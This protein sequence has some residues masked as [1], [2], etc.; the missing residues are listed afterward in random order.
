MRKYVKQNLISLTD[1]LLEAHENIQS[2][3][4]SNDINDACILLADCQGC[5]ESMYDTIEESEG[6]NISTLSIISEYHE[7]LFNLYQQ[8]N[9]DENNTSSKLSLINELLNQ[10]MSSILNDIP[11]KFEIVFLP[12]NASMWDSFDSIYD[13]AMDDS[14]CNVKVIPIPYYDKNPDGSFATFHY[15]GDLYP[16]HIEITNYNEYDLEI[17]RPDVIYIHNPY[18]AAN[19]I[20]SVDPAYYSKVLKKNTD[21]LVYVPYHISGIAGNYNSVINNIMPAFL[22][23]NKMIVQSKS[24]EEY[25]KYGGIPQNRLLTLG[26]PKID[27]IINKLFGT[28]IP[29]SWNITSTY[30]KV[31]LVNTSVSRVICDGSWIDSLRELFRKAEYYDIHMIWRPHPLLEST[32]ERYHPELKAKYNM[33]I[34][35]ISNTNHITLDKEPLAYAAIEV[36]DALISDYSSILFQYIPTG[37]PALMTEN[38]S[39]GRNNEVVCYDYF[40]SYF[41]HDDI[42]IDDFLS[43]VLSNDDPQR[44]E[45]ISAFTSSIAN[46]SGTCGQN[47][48]NSIIHLLIKR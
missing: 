24:M 4:S 14:R 44:N 3:I 42:S 7:E 38:S 19:T 17:N 5:A 47:I 33:F 35:Y 12:Y 11:L 8:I 16:K 41:T 48:H 29:E 45:R 25:Y 30:K 9:S 21:M 46:S 6:S 27:F 36:S 20:T 23:V 22:Y 26:S 18:D 39:S 1:T 2:F 32:L 28:C 10:I 37:K 40:S 34:N 13:A 31:I 15:E 43:M